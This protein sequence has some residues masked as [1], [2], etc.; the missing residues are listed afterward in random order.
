MEITVKLGK[1]GGRVWIHE[2]KPWV[3]RC[4]KSGC[5][6]PAEWM[7][8]ETL[9]EPLCPIHLATLEE[10]RG[11]SAPLLRHGAVP[12]A[13]W[14]ERI[15]PPWAHAVHIGCDR[16]LLDGAVQA[17]FLRD[18]VLTC[19]GGCPVCRVPDGV[20]GICGAR[21]PE[22]EKHAGVA[23][24]TCRGCGRNVAAWRAN[25]KGDSR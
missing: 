6:R 7:T 13:D 9:P 1:P 19:V 21:H 17:G 12:Y 4:C 5:F 3:R 25:L 15:C 24:T 10:T 22:G 20:C 16:G 11:L 2:G 8:V 14:E 23:Y 18:K